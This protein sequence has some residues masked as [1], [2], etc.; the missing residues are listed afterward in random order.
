[1]FC[2]NDWPEARDKF[3]GWW[4]YENTGRPLFKIIAKRD[5]PPDGLTPEK[6]FA[7]PEAAYLDVEELCKRYE[8]FCKSHV[9]MAEAF[10]AIDLN[11]GPG[12]LAL[13]LG[14]EPIFR[15]D[16]VWFKEWVEEGW[17][18]AGAFAFD[19]SNRWFKKHVEILR[20]AQELAGGRYWVNIPDIVENVDILAAMRG[21]QDF[22][23]D[24]IDEPDLMKEYV[25]QLDRQYIHGL[26]HMGAGQ[27]RQNP[28]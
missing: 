7:S 6:A 2:K 21:P 14:T 18:N 28:V 8:N 25:G 23:Y 24:L 4:N 20:R 19:P 9:F 1:M 17:Q 3:I 12:S 11:F 16:T 26:R 5:A 22:C 15:P 13:Y 10:P 27:N